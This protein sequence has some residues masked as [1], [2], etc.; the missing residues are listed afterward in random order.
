MKK[1]LKTVS[2]IVT[3]SII[4][5]M[6]AT[7]S[8]AA[9]TATTGTFGKDNSLTWTVTGNEGAYKLTITGSGAMPN[10]GSLPWI[11]A[12]WAAT[13]ITA[14]D[15]GSGVTQI[16]Y[17]NFK[18]YT[19]LTS[20]TGCEDVTILNGE[21]FM[22]C[23]L[24]TK[25]P[26]FSKLEQFTYNNFNDCV[27]LTGNTEN[28][29]EFVIPA[30]VKKMRQGNFGNC[31]KIKKIIFED[32]SEPLELTNGN[33]FSWMPNLELVV[34][35][36][37]LTSI[38]NKAVYNENGTW[39]AASKPIVF[40]T[41]KG[42]AADIHLSDSTIYKTEVYSANAPQIWRYIKNAVNYGYDFAYKYTWST[43]A[44]GTFMMGG[45]PKNDSGFWFASGKPWNAYN[46]QIKKIVFDE[47]VESIPSYIF[48]KQKMSNDGAY[49]TAYSAVTEIVIPSTVKTI[50]I[51]A[52]MSLRE[53]DTALEKH[54]KLS[55]LPEGLETIGQQAF[56]NV[57]IDVDGNKLVIP[58]SVKTIGKMAFLNSN[59]GGSYTKLEFAKN[60]QCTSIDDSAFSG[61]ANLQYIC[62]P[63]GVSLGTDAFK[64]SKAGTRVYIDGA[65]CTAATSGINPFSGRNGVTLYQPE[66]ADKYTEAVKE[67]FKGWGIP[68]SEGTFTATLTFDDNKKATAVIINDTADEKPYVLIIA[69]YNADGQTLETVEI[70]PE[71]AIEGCMTKTITL[72]P[73][74]MTA[75][76][77]QAFLWD[78]M[79]SLTPLA[80]S[81][82]K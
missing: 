1:V 61:L 56:M 62:L 6:F 18:N 47:G 57:N 58:A 7:A 34:L 24:L 64:A 40:V 10:G 81:L 68:A 71:K 33:N 79:D 16:G 19:K 3:M 63:G 2:A 42:S 9:G 82:A 48:S 66:D 22:G 13:D 49:E 27:S 31:S 46:S 65:P 80:A 37:R 77:Y 52:F 50:N 75:V 11:S 55:A 29:G 21:T 45:K 43:D 53:K 17:Q 5:L 14:V 32:G 12:G 67:I 28:S 78:S 26:G 41:E 73:A 35:P 51:G 20:L 39:N 4:M 8:F 59:Y 23:K 38:E 44:D 54:I 30:A 76:R 60:S 72:E 74:D 70:A 69:G 25:V 15:I 36:K